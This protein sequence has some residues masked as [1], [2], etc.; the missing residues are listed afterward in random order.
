MRK[1]VRDTSVYERSKAFNA[2]DRLRFRHNC[3]WAGGLVSLGIYFGGDFG[4]SISIL[5]LTYL[6]YL[7]S[8]RDEIVDK[9]RPAIVK[10]LISLDSFGE[11]QSRELLGF[12]KCDLMKMFIA[13]GWP[14]TIVVQSGGNDR[15]KDYSYDGE[16][17]WTDKG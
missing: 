15:S 8:T 1:H 11:A 9:I 6:M 4:I 13:F 7:A 3:K 14:P 17:A 5:G 2:L 12:K 10:R 16:T